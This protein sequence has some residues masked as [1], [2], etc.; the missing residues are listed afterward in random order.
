M[1][2]GDDQVDVET[3][4]GERSMRRSPR[5][6]SCAARTYPRKENRVA[7]RPR[8][9]VEGRKCAAAA[10]GIAVTRLGSTR[11]KR[12]TSRRI[13]SE[14]VMMWRAAPVANHPG[15]PLSHPRR[16][17]SPAIIHPSG[18]G[19]P[20]REIMNGH[21]GWDRRRGKERRNSRHETHRP[22]AVSIRVAIR[23]STSG[24]PEDSRRVAGAEIRRGTGSSKADPRRE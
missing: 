14:G 11:K 22:T 13:A 20:R 16:P 12:M 17:R 10:S 6:R 24:A 9:R 15:D 7:G 8:H 1:R 3:A 23:R 4:R 18:T 5:P 2:T 19:C 21:D